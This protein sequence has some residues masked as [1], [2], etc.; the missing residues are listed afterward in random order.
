MNHSNFSKPEAAKRKSRFKVA[1]VITRMEWGGSPDIVRIICTSLR[2]NGYDVKLIMGP[3]KHF[4]GKTRAFLDGFKDR[5]VII[6]SLRRNINPFLDFLALARLHAIFRREKFDI[7][8][9]HTAKAGML[10]RIAAYLVGTPKIIH[11]PHGHNFYGYFGPFMSKS[12]VV[13]ERFVARFTDKIV[14]LT[15]L[16]KKDFLDFEVKGS[17]DIDIIPSG[18]ELNDFHG[19]DNG[20]KEWKRNQLGL[21]SFEKVVGMVSRLEGVKGPEYFIEAAKEVAERINNV[22]FLIVGEGS[23]RSSLERQTEKL[24][25]EG[26]IKFLGW[27]E[28]ALE[29]ITVLDILVQPSLNE[30]VGRVLL[31]AQVS[32]VPVVATGVGGIPEVVRE[33]I[34]GIIVSPRDSNALADAVCNLLEDEKKR[35]E[36]SGEARKWVRDKFSSVKMMEEVLRIYRSISGSGTTSNTKQMNW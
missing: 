3:G 19:V 35:K 25:L 26:K 32:G 9:T 7:V 16:E 30:A 2:E 31:E 14:V 11:M 27:R 20:E 24:E 12:I 18:L 36:M 23:L 17:E 22:K 1:Q 10:G 6:P 28:D 21:N 8:H 5:T 4:S 34:T 29:I 13:L 33:G 15:K